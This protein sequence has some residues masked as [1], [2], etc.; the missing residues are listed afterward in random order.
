VEAC[1]WDGASFR[2]PH[3]FQPNPSLAIN[4]T[5]TGRTIQRKGECHWVKVQIEWVGDGEESRY[6][7]ALLRVNPIT[8][9]AASSRI[10]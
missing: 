9:P 4:V 7:S 6:S 2:F 8:L 5:I 1:E 10:A 3:A